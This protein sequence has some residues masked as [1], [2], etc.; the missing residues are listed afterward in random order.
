MPEELDP[1]KYHIMT[2][3]KKRQLIPIILILLLVIPTLAFFY[4]KFAVTRPSQTEDEI[5]YE[6]KSGSSVLEIADE[7]YDQ[8][9]INSKFLFVF[10][11]FLNDLDEKI[12]AG[13]YIIDAGTPI[14]ELTNILLHG[15]ND[16]R[17]TFLEGWRV[18]EVAAEASR[19]LEEMDYA[20]FVSVAKPLEGYLFPDTYLIDKE[21]TEEDVMRLL[22][23]TFTEKTE[24]LLSEVNL[25]RVGLTRDQVVTFASIVER[26]VSDPE[27]R[28]IV[29]GILIKR[30]REGLMLDADATVQY[31]RAIWKVCAPET[32]IDCFAEGYECNLSQEIINCIAEEAPELDWWPDELNQQDLDFGSPYNTRNSVGL[33]PTPICNPSLNAL[34]S[35]LNHTETDYYYYL[36]DEEG[37]THYAETLDEHNANIQRYL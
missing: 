34:E 29:A 23:N 10:Y 3:E 24:D 16:V 14:D 27:D 8:G 6:L 25:S 31:T 13:T 1:K 15:V 36:T 35:V 20:D 33:P 12:Q 30:W 18:E 26:E 7:L 11:L 21:A 2:P 4:Y 9:A 22:R 28:P 19:K 37:V 5:T 17:I 32:E